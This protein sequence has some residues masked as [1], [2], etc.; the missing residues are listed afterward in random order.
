VKAPL[1]LQI[2]FLTGQ[3]DPPSAALNPIQKAFLD[4]LPVPEACKVRVDFPYPEA[5]PPHRPIP[6]P[7][8][9]W[10]VSRQLLASRR[11]PFAARHRP[12]VQALLGRAD[13]TLFLA[14]S[15]G[16]EL[17]ANLELPSTDRA[18]IHVFAYGPVVR[19]LPDCEVRAVRGR[20]DWI[21]RLGSRGVFRAPLQVEGAHL[22]YLRDPAVLALASSY[23]EEVGGRIAE[24]PGKLR[25]SEAEA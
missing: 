21:S 18:R 2:A 6:L 19:R 14:G 8:A 5:S 10:N 3:G 13:R 1:P 24:N 15:C 23:L 25:C 17:L 7:L 9:S 11:A 4:A 20:R 12:P 16:L 22:D